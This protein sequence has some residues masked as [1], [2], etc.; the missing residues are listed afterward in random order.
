M[1][2]KKSLRRGESEKNSDDGCGS[3]AFLAPEHRE[4]QRGRWHQRQQILWPSPAWI[5]TSL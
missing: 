5:W 4:Q 2:S 1:E 3:E